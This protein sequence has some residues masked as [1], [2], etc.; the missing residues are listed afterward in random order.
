M[1]D[2]KEIELK[3]KKE[4]FEEKLGGLVEKQKYTELEKVMANELKKRLEDEMKRLTE[5]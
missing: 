5:V 4:E 1:L 3:Q 2:K